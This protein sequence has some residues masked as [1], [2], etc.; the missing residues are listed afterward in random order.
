M[1]AHIEAEFERPAHPFAFTILLLPFGMASGYVTVALAY[2]LTQ[3]GLSVERVAGLAALELLPQTWKVLWAP[4]V[5]TTLSARRWYLI[6][7]IVTGLSVLAMALVAAPQKF[8]WLLYVL[9]LVSSIASSFSAISTESLMAHNTADHQRGRAGGWSQAGNLG[10]AGLGGGLALWMSE[11]TNSWGGGALLAVLCLACP[12]ALRYCKDSERSHTASAGYSRA[13]LAVG[14]D[15]WSI[16][17]TR[18]GFLTLLL[19]LLPISTGAASNLWAAVAGEWH[20]GFDTV[21]LVNGVLGGLISMVGCIA[22][23]YATDVI[24]RKSSYALFGIMQALC[25][26]AMALSA[27]TPAY[28][29]LFTCTYAFITGCIWGA[30]SAVTLETIGRHS[31]A[32]NYNLLACCSNIPITYMII[33]DGQAY[34]RWGSSGMLYTEAVLAVCAVLVFAATSLATRTRAV[35]AVIP[36]ISPA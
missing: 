23:G 10:G 3:A 7:T 34:G 30:F 33:I 32:T 19:F 13:L 35:P 1:P 29:V 20:A 14:R 17:R 25:V 9:V 5:D 28:F 22:G 11:H 27:R 24:D 26:A 4:L 21:A 31:A 6:S 18:V 36:P 12:L 16:A 2:L 8:L 15:V